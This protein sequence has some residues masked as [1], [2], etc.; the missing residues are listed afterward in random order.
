MCVRSG[1]LALRRPALASCRASR[2]ERNY[3]G[4]T[5]KGQTSVLGNESVRLARMITGT[6]IVL[7]SGDSEADR[8]F[9]RDVLGFRAVDAGHGWLIF[10]LPPAEAAVHPIDE[11]GKSREE[12]SDAGLFAAEVY[13]MCDD[14][15]AEIK[16]LNAKQI[17]CAP[18]E[19]AR[20]GS[21]TSFRLPSGG[22]L[23]LYEPGHALAIRIKQ[24]K[25]PRKKKQKKAKT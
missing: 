23:G 21:K 3:A 6:H 18:V 16:R 7:F 5:A 1:S 9:L 19:T 24:S 11:G 15:A 17:E 12:K 13:L 20:W 14:L 10:A 2:D 4:S 25:P 8:K 22:R